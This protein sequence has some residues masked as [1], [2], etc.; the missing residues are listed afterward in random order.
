[1]TARQE[2]EE[3]SRA[4]GGC[5]LAALGSIALAA[6][7]AVSREAGILTVWAAGTATVW[8]VARRRKGPYQPLPSPTAPPSR[9]DVFAGETG[10]VA[11]VV[12]SPE[13]VM[14]T[15]HPVRQEITPD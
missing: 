13:G 6:V 11:R 7:F 1:M 10:E 4:A 14:C 5:V 2:P 3:R 15:V 9:G 8:W 12:R